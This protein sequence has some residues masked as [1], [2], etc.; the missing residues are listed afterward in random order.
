MKDLNG[1]QVDFPEFKHNIADFSREVRVALGVDSPAGSLVEETYDKVLMVVLDG[2]GYQ[3]LKDRGLLDML[4]LQTHEVGSVIPSSTPVAL[5]SIITGKPPSEHG[6][7]GFTFYL[8]GVGWFRPFSHSDYDGFEVD[9]KP[10]KVMS[11][12]TIF[13]QLARHRIK[14]EYL[15]KFS[16]SD[17]IYTK[18]TSRGAQ[19]RTFSGYGHLFE[20]L[21]KTVDSKGKRFALTYLDVP[22]GPLHGGGGR[23]AYETELALIFR[24]IEKL[25]TARFADRTLLMVVSDHGHVVSKNRRVP[26]RTSWLRA[27]VAGGDRHLMF[28]PKPRFRERIIHALKPTSYVFEGRAFIEQGGM[29][30]RVNRVSLER[31][32]ELL[33]LSFGK[34]TPYFETPSGHPSEHGGVTRE[35]MSAFLGFSPLAGFEPRLIL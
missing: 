6:I 18:Y 31:A 3:N 16:L 32:P 26:I 35:E 22:D 2:L 28:N 14:S 23:I 15:I 7:L 1:R 13:Q 21:W 4:G 17:T 5:T 27:P 24:L 29:G 10:E 12:E 30:E 25:K 8:P 11:C 33:A 34:H 9:V 19:I 20:K